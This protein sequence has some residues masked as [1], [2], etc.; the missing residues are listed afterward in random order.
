VASKQLRPRVRD[1]AHLFDARRVL[2]FRAE[3]GS[4]RRELGSSQAQSQELRNPAAETVS[5]MPR[6]MREDQEYWGQVPGG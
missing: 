4:E 3:R 1:G 5:A 6:G 2:A